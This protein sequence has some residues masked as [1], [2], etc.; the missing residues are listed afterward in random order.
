M[1]KIVIASNNLGKLNEIGAILAPLD[2][3][4]VPQTSL[5]VSEAEEPHFTFVENALAKA[6]HASRATGLPALADDSG[7]C[8]DALGGA[9]GVHSARFA[10]EPPAGTPRTREAQ[11]ALNNQKLLDLLVNETNRKAHYY[12]VI[13]LTRG[14]DDPRPLICEAEWHGEIVKTPRGT[15]GF[16][17][18]PLFMVAGT[19][20][21]GA[22]FTPDEKNLVS[23][24][25]QALAQLVARL[26]TE[27]GL[28]NSGMPD[29]RVRTRTPAFKSEDDAVRSRIV[30]SRFRTERKKP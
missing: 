10:G 28:R 30:P 6:H 15:G 12:C 27:L 29:E 26:K 7:I 22:E 8:V 23:H 2:I 5:G 9:P 18:D 21:T 11:D 24:R 13:V 14:P 16:G 19:R 25:A 20:K 3:E 1:K 17:Y 4:I